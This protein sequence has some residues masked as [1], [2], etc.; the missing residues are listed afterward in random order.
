MDQ[1]I[2]AKAPLLDH[3]SPLPPEDML[4]LATE[5]ARAMAMRHSNAEVG[6]LL[7]ARRLESGLVELGP[8]EES[9]R[10]EDVRMALRRVAELAIGRLPKE[11]I[12]KDKEM[13]A[14]LPSLVE[15][16]SP[17]WVAVAT[18]AMSSE[19]HYQPQDAL[20]LWEQLELAS[21]TARVRAQA[22]VRPDLRI[23]IAHDTHIGLLKSRMSQTNQDAVFWQSEGSISLLIVADGI[24]VSTAGSGNL[25]SAILVQVIA[26][27]WEAELDRL[28]DAS[29]PDIHTFLDQALADANQAICESSLRMAGGDLTRHI[30][31]GTTALVAVVRGARVHLASLG[32]SRAYLVGASGAAQLTADQNLRGEWLR[33]WQNNQPFDLLN[34][35]YALVGYAGH[36][37][38]EG[39]PSPVAA[40]HRR[41]SLLPG[42]C[43]VLCSDGLTDYAS[44]SHGE[45][46]R[47]LEEAA[48]ESD[49]GAACRT[50]VERAN[51]AGGG[52]NVTVLMARTLPQ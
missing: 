5:I 10:A 52:D 2:P 12:V 44:S 47:F 49:L 34:E 51:A 42:E 31:M 27:K 39:L 18:R 21:A 8:A 7:G 32:D 36:F 37:D 9:T 33:S 40:L 24:S 3:L 4:P 25:A 19:S 28:V 43:L 20:D 23:E 22:P 50:L 6:G 17:E 41:L 45:M 15:A 14:F 11:D 46:A 30:P 29:E 16:P 35:G 13:L 26:S 48:A 1:P 38:E